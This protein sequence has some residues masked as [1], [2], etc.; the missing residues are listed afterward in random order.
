MRPK[1]ELVDWAV[2]VR[3]KDWTREW[4]RRPRVKKEMVRPWTAEVRIVS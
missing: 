4:T 1:R 3:E 2:R